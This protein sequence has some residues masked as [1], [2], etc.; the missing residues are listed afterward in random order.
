MPPL[1]PTFLLLRIFGCAGLYILGSPGL[2]GLD[3]NLDNYLVLFSTVY[4]LLDLG[5]VPRLVYGPGY[6]VPYRSRGVGSPIYPLDLSVYL[7]E[8]IL[9][10]VINF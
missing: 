3:L 6:L 7:V 5:F 4:V 10:S 1:E 8:I 9:S 2:L